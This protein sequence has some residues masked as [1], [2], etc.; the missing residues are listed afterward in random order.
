VLYDRDSND[1]ATEKNRTLIVPVIGH[2]TSLFLTTVERRLVRNFE[3][4]KTNSYFLLD[5]VRLL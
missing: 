4:L 5:R 3:I 2:N 1:D